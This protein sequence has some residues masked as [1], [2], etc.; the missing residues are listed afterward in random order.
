MMPTIR[1]AQSADAPAIARFLSARAETTMFMR[2]GLARF[3]LSGSDHPHAN[4]FWVEETAG[5][6]TGVFARSNAGFV[7]ACGEGSVFWRGFFDA[8][9]GHSISGV[10]GAADMAE[11]MRLTLSLEDAAYDLHRIEPLYRL[12]LDNMV[13]PDPTGSKKI[14]IR[15]PTK[16]DTHTLTAWFR[17]YHIEAL[18]AE[19][20]DALTKIIAARVDQTIATG[21]VRLMIQDGAPV[22]MT[23][24]NAQLPDMV[25]IGGVYTPPESRGQGLARRVVA[26]HLK[27]VRA[28]G[29]KTA[30]LFASGDAACRAY[31]AIGF[32]RIGEY[33]LAILS[34]P[35]TIGARP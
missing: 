34:N 2:A 12:A 32:E 6:I 20:D 30:I 9:Q 13:E 19:D 26:A 33:T 18:G 25:Q 28:Q 29:V 23:A 4:T 7:N 5:K 16:E 3:G 14:Q 21:N 22:A 8:M 31:E 10:N 35:V 1:P 27:E 15:P 17:A 11:A 24:F